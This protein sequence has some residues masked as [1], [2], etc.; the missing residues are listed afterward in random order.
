MGRRSKLTPEIQ[1]KIVIAIEAGN[2]A[3]AACRYAGID[4]STF[5]R[6]M[7]KGEESDDQYGEFRKAVE[8]ARAHAEVK[9]VAV[10]DRAARE[11]TWQAAA[12]WLERTQPQKYGR[13]ERYEV[14]GPDGGNIVVDVS[15]EEL[16]SK[17]NQILQA[18]QPRA[19]T[20]GD[21]D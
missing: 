14:S 11:G 10:I 17:V 1:E 19:I 13:K 15:M 16:E 8:K 21:D 7:Q 5:F 12:W 6:W 9:Y 20:A 18:R 3:D 4:Y 2:Y